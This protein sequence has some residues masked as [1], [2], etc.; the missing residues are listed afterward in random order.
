MDKPKFR[1]LRLPDDSRVPDPATGAATFG[2]YDTYF[3]LERTR[4][5]LREWTA[6]C[7]SVEQELLRDLPDSGLSEEERRQIVEGLVV[8]HRTTLEQWT[9]SAVASAQVQAQDERS[10]GGGSA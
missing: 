2:E 6:D 8:L 7:V 1:G 10:E 4:V 5:D 9:R 3:T